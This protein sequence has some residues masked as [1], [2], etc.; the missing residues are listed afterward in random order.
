MKTCTTL[1]KRRENRKLFS[2]QAVKLKQFLKKTNYNTDD[3][4]GRY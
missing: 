2:V 3:L 1:H 4:C